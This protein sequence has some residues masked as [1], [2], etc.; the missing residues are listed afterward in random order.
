M[1]QNDPLLEKWAKIV[2]QKAGLPAI[3][4]T[5]SEV[6]RTFGQI[7]DR[8]RD[9]ERKLDPFQSG[10]VI[11]VQIGND[12]DWPSILV[13]CWRRGLPVLPLEQSISEQQCDTA[14]KICDVAGITTGSFTVV[15]LR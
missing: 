1:K 13:A 3:L 8:A 4:N 2:A 15:Q 9:F 14:L 11:A 12:E 5:R 7:D 6:A 10:S